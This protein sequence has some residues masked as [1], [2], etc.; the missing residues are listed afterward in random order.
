MARTSNIKKGDR[1]DQII[2]EGQGIKRSS[3]IGEVFQGS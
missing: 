3:I 1:R 2:F